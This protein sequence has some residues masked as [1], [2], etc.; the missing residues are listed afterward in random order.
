MMKTTEI[1]SSKN[2]RQ[3]TG[4]LVCVLEWVGKPVH[5]IFTADL[6]ES[7]TNLQELSNSQRDATKCLTFDIS[8]IPD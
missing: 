4:W 8:I 6:I 1:K 3:E 7:G 5:S 2:S